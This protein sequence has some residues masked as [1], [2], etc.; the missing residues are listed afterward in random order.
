MISLLLLSP[1][2]LERLNQKKKDT[3]CLSNYC[4][5]GR[6]SAWAFVLIVSCLGGTFLLCLMPGSCLPSHLTLKSADA[7]P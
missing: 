7:M 4:A 5:H 1:Y 6:A 3:T 2:L